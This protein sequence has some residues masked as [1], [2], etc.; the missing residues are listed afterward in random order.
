MVH[1]TKPTH[2]KLAS[3]PWL[4]VCPSLAV[5]VIQ[6]YSTQEPQESQTLA[7][8][9]GRTWPKTTY[10]GGTPSGKVW[11]L[12]RRG[13]SRHQ[14]KS[15]EKHLNRTPAIAAPPGLIS[16]VCAS[17]A[18]QGLVYTGTPKHTVQNPP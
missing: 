8:Q 17:S 18:S 12:L 14:R 6:G 5:N 3:L 1:Q 11:K 10:S 13:S 2:T 16:Q 4:V 9:H 15:T 7:L